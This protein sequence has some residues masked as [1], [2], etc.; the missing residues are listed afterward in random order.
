MWF[1][2]ANIVATIG[3][4]DPR[5]GLGGTTYYLK[6]ALLYFYLSRHF[7]ERHLPWLL[8]AFGFT[9]AIETLLGGYQFA[10]GKLVG[11]VVDK[12]LGNSDTLNNFVSGSGETTVPGQ[13]SWHRASGTLTE[14]HALGQFLGMLLPF[15]AVLFLT[16]RLRPVL[17]LL[18]LIAAGGAAMTIVFTLAR[19]PYVGVGVSLA[20]GVVL[21]LALW[22]ER[23]V[24]AGLVVLVLLGALIAPFVAPLLYERL[25]RATNTLDARA[26]IYWVALQVF[27]DHALFG[28]GP[29]NWVW[30]YPSYDQGWLLLDWYSNLVHNDILLTAAEVGIFGLVPYIGI[31]LSAGRR[32]FS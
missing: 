20:L 8:A 9:I 22:G 5:L 1:M 21:I 31:L 2:L 7:D 24:V 26:P 28:I 23:Q 4:T 16:P 6:Y 3:S 15:C 29:G 32:L 14:P 11:L 30:V 27:A 17:R 25:T 12:G 10:T 18:S 13:G 19:G